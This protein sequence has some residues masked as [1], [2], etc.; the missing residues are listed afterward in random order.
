MSDF[1]GLSINYEDK[2]E[3]RSSANHNYFLVDSDFRKGQIS[4]MDSILIQKYFVNAVGS[5]LTDYRNS[6][7]E[8]QL[9]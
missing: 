6:T 5:L 7:K 2:Y 1:T 9:L 4:Q 8:E 3:H